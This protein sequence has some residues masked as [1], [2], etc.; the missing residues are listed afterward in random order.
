MIKFEQLE[1][2]HVELSS[3]CNAACPSCPRNVDG[4]YTIPWLIPKTMSLEDFKTIFSAEVLQQVKFFLMCGNYGDPIYCKDLPD[5]LSYIRMLNPSIVC[6]IHTNGGIRNTAWWS[7][8]AKSNSN[9]HVVFSIDGLADTNHIY[10]R[11]VIWDRVIENAQSFIDAGGSATWEFLVFAH[12]EHQIEDAR[13]TATR[14]KFDNFKV[15]RPFGFEFFHESYSTM[16]VIDEDGTFAYF[17]NQASDPTLQNKA[18]SITPDTTR[19]RYDMPIN[20]FKQATE[21]LLPHTTEYLK[22]E[23]AAFSYLDDTEISCMTSNNREI[24]VDSN[25][26]VHPCCFLGVESQLHNGTPDALQYQHWLETNINK[27][28]INAKNKSLKE[29]VNGEFF[30][31]IEETW[32]HT[33]EN[34][35]M[36]CCSKMCAK[37]P[38]NYTTN[39]YV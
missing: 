7:Q 22:K 20:K 32:L 37:K 11:N 13:S 28:E 24:Y 15:K 1:R 23:L 19:M 26:D 27:T 5:I 6:K 39:L 30:K 31:K 36:L 18:H 35:R 38:K 21:Q 33:H 3:A 25:G 4:G 12:N 9:I 2:I 29:I 34:G 8:L 16:R 17:I 10:R 14:M